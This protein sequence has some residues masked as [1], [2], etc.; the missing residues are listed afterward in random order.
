[1]IEDEGSE[2]QILTFF[3][4]IY[5]VYIILLQ[6]SGTN[7]QLSLA[8]FSLVDYVEEMGMCGYYNILQEV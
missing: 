6:F 2:R 8:F 7:Q 5:S 3:S 1:M 4:F